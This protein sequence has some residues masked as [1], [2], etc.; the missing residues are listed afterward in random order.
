[1]YKLLNYYFRCYQRADCSNG[2][3][4]IYT[5]CYNIL[6]SINSRFILKTNNYILFNVI[7]V[8]LNYK[9]YKCIV[10]VIECFFVII[11]PL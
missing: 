2:D 9:I 8:I 3:V 7:F 11:N 5:R 6:L 4:K 1:M 10:F